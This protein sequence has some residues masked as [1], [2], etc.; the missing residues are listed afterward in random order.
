MIL[1]E[2]IL[3]IIRGIVKRPVES[4]LLIV[5]IA[6]GIGAAASGIS[7]VIQ[8]ADESAKMLHETRYREI[9]VK[10]RES[11]QEMQSPAEQTQAGND[12]FL[13]ANDLVAKNNVQAVEY[14]YV[15]NRTQI[16]F[17]DFRNM[18]FAQRSDNG[19]TTVTMVQKTDQAQNQS[20]DVTIVQKQ[21]TTGEKTQASTGGQSRTS[22]DVQ[23]QGSA[24]GQVIA[25]EKT[26]ANGNAN[27]NVQPPFPDFFDDPNATPLPEIKGP[28]PVIE[29]IVGYEV[30]PEYFSAYGLFADKGSLFT[31]D[32][33]KKREPV[34]ILGSDIAKTLFEDGV[35]LDRQVQVHREI[36]RIVGIL[37]P[38]GTDLDMAGFVPVV[39]PDPNATDPRLRMRGWNMNLRFAVADTS[40]LDQAKAQ[41][42]S[43][44]DA[45]YGTGTMVLAVPREEALELANRNS[46]LVTIILILAISGLLIAS[47]NVSNILFSRGLRKR[48]G[49][50]IMK[51]MGATRWHIFT[52]FFT[53]ALIIG[54]SGAV[55]GSGV[56]VLL[57]GLM[58]SS[59]GVGGYSIGI[60]GLG[61]LLSLAT[62][63]FLT[64]IPAIQTSKI[65]ASEAIRYE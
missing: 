50:G 38:T 7:I 3:V 30:S 2:D 10:N 40:N 65:P 24:G 14:A 19:T 48:K 42:A 55:L 64:N 16:D 61:V 25:G 31:D 44:F 41:L 1:R 47:V 57:S 28:K 21:S 4:L 43:Y 11:A 18:Q 9:V 27:T 34:M 5:G 36:Y 17:R 39:I 59:L 49:I 23:A 56:A 6:L 62:T 46:R 22:T 52:L 15:A 26:G 20:A 29:E 12:V 37:K 33:I 35:S 53:E 45:Q 32:D 54:V 60:L 58:K 51:A 8:T 63:L 13:T